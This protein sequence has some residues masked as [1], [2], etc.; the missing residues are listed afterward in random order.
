MGGRRGAPSIPLVFLVVKGEE[1]EEVVSPRI[2]LA[3]ARG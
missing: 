1:E 3:V 2:L